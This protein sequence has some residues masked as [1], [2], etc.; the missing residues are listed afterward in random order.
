MNTI[1]KWHGGKHFLYKHITPLITG[2]SLVEPYAGGL[3]VLINSPKRAS[4]IANDLNTELINCYRWIKTAQ[5][6]VYHELNKITYSKQTWD[7]FPSKFPYSPLGA[8]QYIARNRFSRGGLG[9]HFGKS[10]R[11]RGGQFQKLF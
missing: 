1:V 4:E 6:D 5:Q 2:T 9:K 7:S 8:A 10:S 11:L 3:S